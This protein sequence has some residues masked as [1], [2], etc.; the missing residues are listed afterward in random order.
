M[1]RSGGGTRK[2]DAVRNLR[3]F[4]GRPI[5]RRCVLSTLS[6]IGDVISS[7]ER[8]GLIF[9]V[10]PATAISTSSILVRVPPGPVWARPSAAPC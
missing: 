7:R 9:I 2:R 6:T 5:G 3:I 8:F 1:S 4:D 10:R